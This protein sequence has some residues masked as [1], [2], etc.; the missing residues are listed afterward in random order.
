MGLSSLGLGAVAVALAL[1]MMMSPLPL[2]HAGVYGA[3]YKEFQY[4]DL[5]V[6]V[7]ENIVNPDYVIYYKGINYI[8]LNDVGEFMATDLEA[9]PN[10]KPVK[11]A[12][13]LTLREVYS[14]LKPVKNY[15]AF[16]NTSMSGSMPFISV[17]R[18]YGG[19]EVVVGPNVDLAGASMMIAEALQP[20][21]SSRGY[22]ILM[23]VRLI[24]NVSPKELENAGKAYGDLLNSVVFNT[25]KY[26]NL[27][28]YLAQI[29]K[30]EKKGLKKF[31]KT[32]IG[33]EY[34]MVGIGTYGYLDIDFWGP[35]PSRDQVYELVKWL[36]D[37]AGY[38][39]VPLTI[40]F[41]KDKP[42]KISLLPEIEHTGK[43][44]QTSITTG[45][46]ADTVR[47]WAKPLSPAAILVLASTLFLAAV[48]YAW[49]RK[50]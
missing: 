9:I 29:M 42:P 27:P 49:L 35:Q 5:R 31:Q 33:T 19:V 30:L 13:N 8:S 22:H 12:G 45:R 6:I 38:P 16:Y 21:L 14:A 20:L 10:I 7:Y 32:G 34:H 28:S 4:K 37:N 25:E 36:R 3:R 15:L 23:V 46:A 18:R 24:S 44:S 48:A 17:S 43:A 47:S 2:V 1:I 39:E 40:A 41:H 11:N 26:G 50:H